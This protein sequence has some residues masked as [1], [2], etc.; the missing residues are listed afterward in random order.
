[1]IS[2]S[3][4]LET[5]YQIPNL[6]YLILFKV[7]KQISNRTEDLYD[8]FKRMC[9]NILYKNKDDHGNNFAFIYDDLYKSY[10][11]SPFYDITSTKD[12]LEHEMTLLGKGNPNSEDIIESISKIGLDRNKCLDI[13]N[14]VKSILS[15]VNNVGNF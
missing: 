13:L 4:L 5:S 6:D 10:V 7:I 11:L 9:F 14:N 8:A 12:K 15:T 2:L 3:S 1:M